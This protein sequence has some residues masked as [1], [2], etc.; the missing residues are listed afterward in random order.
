VRAL[1]KFEGRWPLAPHNIDNETTQAR[2]LVC[3]GYIEARAEP[4]K[5]AQVTVRR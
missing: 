2:L 4:S 1:C 5:T 3:D